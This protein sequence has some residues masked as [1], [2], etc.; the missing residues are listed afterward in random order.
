[1]TGDET[2]VEAVFGEDS[3][4]ATRPVPSTTDLTIYATLQGAPS[5]PVA[6]SVWAEYTG[7]VLRAVRQWA[8]LP[9]ELTLPSFE[10]VDTKRAMGSDGAAS[11]ASAAGCCAGSVQCD[12]LHDRFGGS[13]GGGPCGGIVIVRCRRYQ[14]AR[15][16]RTG[17][18]RS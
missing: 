13:A 14:H 18:C 3:A 9:T 1:M 5:R 6:D 17:G 10:L 11:C 16:A 4:C 12:R 15:D 7:R 8:V 2:R